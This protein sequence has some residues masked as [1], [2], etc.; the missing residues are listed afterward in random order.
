MKIIIRSPKN[1]HEELFTSIDQLKTFLSNSRDAHFKLAALLN[2]KEEVIY[3]EEAAAEQPDIDSDGESLNLHVAVQV[4]E[5]LV[6]VM[7]MLGCNAFFRHVP[8]NYN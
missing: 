3:R 5:S 7:R 8:F 6:E 1:S 2:D 4:K